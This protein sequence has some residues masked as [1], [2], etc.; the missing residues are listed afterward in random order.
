M[1]WELRGSGLRGLRSNSKRCWSNFSMGLGLVRICPLRPSH[2]ASEPA[3]M[4]D[5]SVVE[6]ES[7]EKRGSAS[8]R[9]RVMLLSRV[10]A[11]PEIHGSYIKRP[12]L[13]QKFSLTI[14]EV[15]IRVVKGVDTVDIPLR[16]IPLAARSMG[17][18]PNRAMRLDT[19]PARALRMREVHRSS[20]VL[21]GAI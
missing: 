17:G 10:Y 15:S 12:L 1:L 19:R 21:G 16:R 11:P 9:I 2:A 4:S 6:S 7:M 5:G 18:R 14:R 3:E 13:Y 8:G 20:A